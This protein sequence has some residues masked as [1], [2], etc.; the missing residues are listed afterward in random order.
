MKKF[1]QTLWGNFMNEPITTAAGL[2]VIGIATLRYV[3]GADA[4]EYGA[5]LGVGLVLLGMKDP[6]NPNRPPNF[7][8]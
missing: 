1:L 4:A 3:R 7:P 2:L 5:E 8:V 6:L